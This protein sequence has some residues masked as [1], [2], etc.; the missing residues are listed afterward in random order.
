MGLKGAPNPLCWMDAREEE[1][2]SQEES[3]L[4]WSRITMGLS[5]TQGSQDMC[6]P[7]RTLASLSSLMA[8]FVKHGSVSACL[9]LLSALDDTKQC[10]PWRAPGESGHW[11]RQS[12]SSLQKGQWLRKKDACC[13]GLKFYLASKIGPFPARSFQ[14]P[15]QIVREKLSSVSFENVVFLCQGVQRAYFSN[16]SHQ[17]VHSWGQGRGLH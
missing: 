5:M 8:F 7:E 12:L 15:P 4:H 6:I 13:S 3:D 10:G 16:S 2:Q 1:T 17:S 11:E 9:V 14:D